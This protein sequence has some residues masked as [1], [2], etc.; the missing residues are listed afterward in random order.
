MVSG[1]LLLD[2]I[3]TILIFVCITLSAII[4]ANPVYYGPPLKVNAQLGVME[5]QDEKLTKDNKS[6]DKWSSQ[7]IYKPMSPLENDLKNILDSY[8]NDTEDKI[9]ANDHTSELPTK[10]IQI[11]NG[12]SNSILDS[13]IKHK[14]ETPKQS[15][16]DRV[17]METNVIEDHKLHTEMDS[18]EN[19]KD[20]E[21]VNRSSILTKANF[22]YYHPIH[23]KYYNISSNNVPKPVSLQYDSTTS[24]NH[25]KPWN[26]LHAGSINSNKDMAYNNNKN[27]HGELVVKPTNNSNKAPYKTTQ[28]PF[29][30]TGGSHS[31]IT[32][33][34]F[35][36]TKKTTHYATVG[37]SFGPQKPLFGHKP[38]VFESFT[39]KSN[40]RIPHKVSHK[41]TQKSL[42]SSPQTSSNQY[43]HYRPPKPP[44]HSNISPTGHIPSNN[45]PPFWNHITNNHESAITNHSSNTLSPASYKPIYLHTTRGP[46][47]PDA[48]SHNFSYKPTSTTSSI[49]IEVNKPTSVEMSIKPL[50]KPTFRPVVAEAEPQLVLEP[51]NLVEEIIL[52]QEVVVIEQTAATFVEQPV[53]PV[54]DPANIPINSLEDVDRLLVLVMQEFV[55]LYEQV[56]SPFMNE[57]G[58]LLFGKS[59]ENPVS[60]FIIFGLPVM[61]AALSAVGAGTVA[62]VAAAWIFPLITL[63]FVPQLQ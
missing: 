36:P 38:S 7:I 23:K 56:I 63:L 27:H 21:F 2:N 3:K 35:Y 54:T 50:Y 32:A 61:T 24:L 13:Y 51:P 11:K 31:T 15:F 44:V 34:P 41:T 4:C 37:S 17:H 49:G 22:S 25:I 5:K 20:R 52:P 55:G 30:P 12:Y 46:S 57:M 47:K 40:N 1:S 19:V 62:I 59:G 8:W 6:I 45:H 60:L 16:N 33:F 10:L 48:M 29:K 18:V 42:P 53:E 9:E 14:E 39:K 26:T 58:N 43:T 28:V